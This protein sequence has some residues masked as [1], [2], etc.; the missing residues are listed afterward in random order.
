M[1][2]ELR[3]PA[4]IASSAWRGLRQRLCALAPDGWPAA[5]RRWQRQASLALLAPRCLVC[6]EAGALA[7]DLCPGCRDELPWNLDACRQC[8][9]PAAPGQACCGA[10]TLAP[11]PYARAQVAFHYRFPVDRLLPRLKFHGDLAAGALLATLVQWT[12]DPDDYPQL[13]LPVPLH[14]S[15]LRQ[16]GYDQALELAR[17]LARECRLPLCSDR[18][19]RQRPTQAQTELGAAARQ[20]NVRG[21]FALRAGPP[22]PAHVALVDDVMTT[23]ATLGECAR[24]LRAAGVQRVDVWAVARAL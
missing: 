14:R 8:A 19:W 24:L 13:L 2:P 7:L 10:C 5:G 4:H 23:G 9:L 17:A 12:L 3:R 15:R 20:G 11:P 1:P 22:L 18:L 16:R 21:A 6:G